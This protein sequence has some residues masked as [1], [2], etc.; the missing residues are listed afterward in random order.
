MHFV[1]WRV[2]HFYWECNEETHLKSFDCCSPSCNRLMVCLPCWQNVLTD[3]RTFVLINACRN[4]QFWEAYPRLAGDILVEDSGNYI[5]LCCLPFHLEGGALWVGGE[6]GGG[7]GRGGVNGVSLSC[8]CCC[9]A[10]FGLTGPGSKLTWIPRFVTV[11]A[12]LRSATEVHPHQL[13]SLPSS[14]LLGGTSGRRCRRLP[15]LRP[16]LFC[17]HDDNQSTALLPVTW[18]LR[19]RGHRDGRQ[20]RTSGAFHG[21]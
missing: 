21:R 11:S 20:W 1:S 19:W 5:G 7:L 4:Y 15:A 14:D 13:T 17:L 3:T 16:P 2:C 9:H 6:G 10:C 8:C 12:W 18:Y